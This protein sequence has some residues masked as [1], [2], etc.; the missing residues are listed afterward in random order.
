[1]PWA[2]KLWYLTYPAHMPRGS[3][4]KLYEL[5]RQLNVVA[6]PESVGGTHAN[7]MIHYES[8]QLIMGYYFVDAKGNVRTIRPAELE[9]ADEIFTTGNAG[10]VQPVRDAQRHCPL[11]Q[12]CVGAGGRP[13]RAGLAVFG[14]RPNDGFRRPPDIDPLAGLPG[15]RSLRARRHSGVPVMAVTRLTTSF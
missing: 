3:D 14:H 9:E 5:D 13:R 1:M 10:K 4:D 8:N 6:R 11:A 12:R 7:R 15:Q 2:G